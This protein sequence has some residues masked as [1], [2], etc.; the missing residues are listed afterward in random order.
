MIYVGI[1]IAKDGHV[2]AAVDERGR[3]VGRALPFPNTAAGFE[4]LTAWLG[5][6]A[7]GPEGAAAV[8]MEATG[9]YWMACFAHLSAGGWPACVVNPLQVR[10]VRGLRGRLGV[11]T[12]AVD[13]ALVAETMRVGSAGPSSLASDEVQSLRVLTRLREEMAAQAA[14]VK[15]RALCLLDAYFPEYAALFSDVFGAASRAVLRECPTPGEVSRKRTSTL[16]R[17]LSGASRGRLGEGR[18]AQLKAAAA[19]SVGMQEGAAA[20]SLAIGTLVREVEYLRARTD[21]LDAEIAGLLEG[22]EPLVLTVPGVSRVTGAQIVAEVGDFSRFRDARALVKYAGLDPGSNQ[23]GRFE[24]PS[25]HITKHGSPHLRR[26]FYLAA[27]SA[28]RHDPRMREFYERKRAEGKPHRVAVTACARK[29]CH[30]VF[31]V[32]RDQVPYDPAR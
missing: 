6:V 13:A 23:S 31:A 12:D 27:E 15:Q 11:K 32:V 25:C 10:A 30:Y 16:A 2:A 18:A 21:E 14:A 19:R 28:R 29:M 24:A 4:R 9:P 3:A 7:G 22:V 8:G 5:R 26:A 1:D 17:M 20:A